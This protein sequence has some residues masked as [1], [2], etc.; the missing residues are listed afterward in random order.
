M[1]HF[2]GKIGGRAHN[3]SRGTPEEIAR[4]EVSEDITSRELRLVLEALII[5]NGGSTDHAGYVLAVGTDR[6]QPWEGLSARR[7]PAVGRDWAEGLQR[8]DLILCPSEMTGARAQCTAGMVKAFDKYRQ[9]WELEA[10]Q[11]THPRLQELKAFCRP[12]QFSGRLTPVL[13]DRGS[14]VAF[15]EL[16]TEVLERA[17]WR[18][19][20]TA[21][22]VLALLG[23]IQRHPLLQLEDLEAAPFTT[24]ARM[25]NSFDRRQMNE[26]YGPV[27]DTRDSSI[28]MFPIHQTEAASCLYATWASLATPN[29]PF[30][31]IPLAAHLGDVTA[32]PYS[33]IQGAILAAVA[34]LVGEWGASGRA[35][36]VIGQ[37]TNLETDGG[38]AAD[39]RGPV[40]HM[41]TASEEAQPGSSSEPGQRLQ[42]RSDQPLVDS[43]INVEA[44]GKQHVGDADPNEKDAGP[45][46][47]LAQEGESEGDHR[48][49]IG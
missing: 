9:R 34:V 12:H 36:P 49:V 28:L 46:D 33:P 30:I 25:K 23:D 29:F 48:E 14:L 26:C 7:I 44:D 32:W 18:H 47:E 13:P 38:A 43:G 42:G 21:Q 19:E 8:R 39:G 2:Y 15:L 37:R 27:R 1:W 40:N 20:G 6:L 16:A 3:L 5:R 22:W 24:A 41:A 31:G 35:R 4:V 11:Q 10:E 45:S 17:A